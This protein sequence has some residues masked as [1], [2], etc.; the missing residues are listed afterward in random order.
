M[1][2]TRLNSA[3]ILIVDDQA[4]NV[5]LLEGILQEEDLTTYQSVTDARRRGYH[6]TMTTCGCAESSR[7]SAS[8]CSR[9][10]AFTVQVS[11]R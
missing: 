7:Y 8:S 10:E 2:E 4:S 9:D 1:P 3:K 6:S 11:D 5:L